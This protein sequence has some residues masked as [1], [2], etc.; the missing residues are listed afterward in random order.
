MRVDPSQLLNAD[1]IDNSLEESIVIELTELFPNK[2][3]PRGEKKKLALSLGCSQTYITIISKKYGF[4]TG[5]RFMQ[6]KKISTPRFK[7]LN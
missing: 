3:I 2:I 4:K 1:P 5:R 7:I 6:T